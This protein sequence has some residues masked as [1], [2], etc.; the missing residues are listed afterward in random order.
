M[1]LLGFDSVRAFRFTPLL[2][3]TCKPLECIGCSI[4][5]AITRLVKLANN[6]EYLVAQRKAVFRK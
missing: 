5:N 1:F 4:L 3:R 6:F 2:L